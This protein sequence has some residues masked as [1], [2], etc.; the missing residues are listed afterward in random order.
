MP[1]RFLA[2]LAVALALAAPRSQEERERQD[3]LVQLRSHGTEATM[4]SLADLRRAEP[5]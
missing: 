1:F 3:G 2:V 5:G 4:H